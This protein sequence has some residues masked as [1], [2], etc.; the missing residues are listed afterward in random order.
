MGG[1]I[2]DFSM[3]SDFDPNDEQGLSDLLAGK[4]KRLSVEVLGL[5]RP[6]QLGFNILTV[7]AKNV[8]APA[9]GKIPEDLKEVYSQAVAISR[10]CTIPG[11][12]QSKREDP[13][14][15]ENEVPTS[16][17]YA[18]KNLSWF[19]PAADRA[20]QSAASGDWDITMDIS[21]AEK[22]EGDQALE[23]DE[24]DNLEHEKE[25][26]ANAGLSEDE[27]EEGDVLDDTM[28][29]VSP[30]N[31]G[32]E[33]VDLLPLSAPVMVSWMDALRDAI[34]SA[35]ANPGTAYDSTHLLVIFDEIKNAR[36][37]VDKKVKRLLSESCSF[38]LGET[39]EVP[40]ASIDDWLDLGLFS[41]NK[42]LSPHAMVMLGWILAMTE[43]K[44][45]KKET[46]V[47]SEAPKEKPKPSTLPS[48]LD[49]QLKLLRAKFSVDPVG[50]GP[51]DHC[52]LESTSEA[53][54]TPATPPNPEAAKFYSIMKE[55]VAVNPKAPEAA[56]D[57]MHRIGKALES[58]SLS[59]CFDIVHHNPDP[60]LEEDTECMGAMMVCALGMYG[61]FHVGEKVRE[62]VYEY[63]QT[64][65][66]KPLIVLEQQVSLMA[67][68]INTMTQ[69][70]D[71]LKQTVRSLEEDIRDQESTTK[72]ILKRCATAEMRARAI[73]AE[74]KEIKSMLASRPAQAPAAPAR[75]V[76]APVKVAEKAP[77]KTAAKKQ[78]VRQKEAPKPVSFLDRIKALD[79]RAAQEEPQ[80]QGTQPPTKKK[81]VPE[82]RPAPRVDPPRRK[83]LT[84][85]E[86]IRLTQQNKEATPFG[87]VHGFQSF[88]ERIANQDA[89]SEVNDDD[90]DGWAP[91]HPGASELGFQT[92]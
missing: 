5:N 54:T 63:V 75:P 76:S 15:K 50:E 55:W 51:T 24:L 72:E 86:K 4:G 42:I 29:E 27:G 39:K 30:A 78:E 61:T 62:E 45:G 21:D 59:E 70:R 56:Y 8:P 34:N 36:K 28:V 57:L 83:Q 60:Q 81:V 26:L 1:H 82:P 79:T 2:Q 9:P 14:P 44:S 84:L 92:K 37:P 16:S 71:T 19:T 41:W 87:S 46:P 11:L 89:V 47:L 85:V 25:D 10:G 3:K 53:E 65:V 13:R 67:E 49:S 38:A 91:T 80:G 6:S 66:A 17:T 48:G 35:K 40:V 69:E 90:K 18:K 32:T 7:L 12:S 23:E 74:L 20:A 22:F 68:E 31:P 77:A 73:E 88:A 64:E 33:V 43:I 58:M 52:G